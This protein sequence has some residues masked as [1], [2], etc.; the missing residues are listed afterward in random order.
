MNDFLMEIG[1]EELPPKSLLPLSEALKTHVEEL[2]TTAGLSYDSLHS[3]AA[4]RRLALLIDNLAPEQPD[5]QVEKRGPALSAAFDSAGKP[6][7]AALGFAKSCNTSIEALQTLKTDQGEW[8]VHRFQQAGQETAQLMPEIIQQAVAK[9]PIP[10]PMR[11]GNHTIEFI[12]P[13]HWVVMIYHHQPIQTTLLGCQTGQTTFGHRVHH[14]DPILIETPKIYAQKLEK[15]YVITDF[16]TRKKT[17]QQQLK[18]QADRLNAIVVMPESLLDEVTGLVEW[19]VVLKASFEESFLALP[20]EV[21]IAAMQHHQKSFALRGNHGKLLPH[22]L[23]AANIQSKNPSAVITGNER[24]MRARLSDAAFFFE[25]DKKETLASRRERTKNVVFQEKLG[26]LYDKSER[27]R[28]ISIYL[29]SLLSITEKDADHIAMLSKCDLM[30]DMV[31]E[32][33]ELQGTMGY[34][35]ALA[36]GEPLSIAIALNEQ[37]WPRFSGDKLPATTL[38]SLLAIAERADTLIGAFAIGQKPSG[39]KDPFKLRRQ[40]LGLIRLLIENQLDCD[41]AELLNTALSAYPE[42]LI[43]PNVVQETKDFIL[44]RLKVFY[45]EA[46]HSTSLIQAVI[47]QHHSLW[48]FHQRIKALEQF[49]QQEEAESLAS[50]NKRVYRILESAGLPNNLVV[51]ETLLTEEAEKNLVKE[52]QEKKALISGLNY[53]ETL[54]ILAKLRQPIDAFFDTVMVNAEEPDLRN[55]RLAILNELRQL[56]IQ[57]ADFSHL[58]S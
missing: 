42:K 26:S 16:E 23:T 9:L 10:K 22:F 20:E 2:L 25:K 11:W 8:L 49:M 30:T 21:L 57:V 5:K 47:G 33:P 1:C 6:T 53:V 46:G 24:V 38:G 19:P 12:R 54:K 51:D 45:N 44:E 41:L 43:K 28:K 31:N 50:A 7:P 40:A 58:A 35:Y 39:N 14:P 4:P 55:N 37:Y 18:E 17:L 15:A 36:D 34:Y 29:S 3:Y 32:F 56:F 27:L 48:D 13:V 52:I